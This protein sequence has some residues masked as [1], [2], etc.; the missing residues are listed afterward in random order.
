MTVFLLLLVAAILMV[1]VTLL[2]LFARFYSTVWDRKSELALYRAI[3]ASQADLKK[4]IIGEMGALVGVV[5]AAC[6]MALASVSALPFELA[7]AAALAAVVLSAIAGWVATAFAMRRVMKSSG[8]QML[9]A[10]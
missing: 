8:G 10:A 7:L 5:G 9:V 1:V 6:A 2:Q 3:G 4:L